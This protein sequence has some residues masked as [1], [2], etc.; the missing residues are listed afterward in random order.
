M[1]TVGLVGAGGIAMAHLGAFVENSHVGAVHVVDPSAEA[2]GR[3]L[4][5][6]GIVKAAHP[7]IEPV[8]E[9]PE[10]RIVD[11]CTPHYLHARQAIR[12]LEAGKDVIVE[13][14]MAMNVAECDEMLEVAGRTG[15]RLFV[16]LCQRMY[17][18]HIEAKRLIDAGEIGE[19][20]LGVV[21][22]YGNELAR[23]KDPDSW[24]GHWERAGGGALFDTGYHAVYMLQHFLGHTTA[25]MACAKQLAV[26]LP[27]KAD[28]TS[29]L[30]MELA[31]KRLGAVTVTYAA[32]GD[33]W[34]EER[35]IVGSEGSL[36]IR[37][38][39][40]DGYPLL[41]LQGEEIVP[42]RVPTPLHVHPYGVA[43]VL[44]H[45]IE[46]ILKDAPE[47]V[48]AAEARE[49]VAV[50]EAAYLSEREGR[51]VEVEE[52]VDE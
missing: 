42:V 4:Q 40:E 19:P 22:I 30:A 13:K 46:C 17:P 39:P 18:A 12:A 37:D 45:F 14:P 47:E 7:N 43:R 27:D 11:V 34:T 51:R 31:G 2:R 8:L 44:D 33:R 28:D 48:T 20:F 24:K 26:G 41:L 52:V 15:Q 6:F 10:I 21:N 29:V 35:R 9:D 36:L 38:D 16:A 32:T 1:L 50:C 23:M 3:A 25:V 5:Q 49:A